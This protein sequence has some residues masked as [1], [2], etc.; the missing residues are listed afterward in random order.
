MRTSFTGP[1]R[2]PA[3]QQWRSM[4]G[5]KSVW[6]RSVEKCKNCKKISCLVLSFPF[7]SATEGKHESGIHYKG[8]QE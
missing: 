5:D 8:N 6:N 3:V 1:R 4:S 2:D 7:A